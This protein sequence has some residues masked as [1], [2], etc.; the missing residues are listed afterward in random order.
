MGA[1]N[2]PVPFLIR[3]QSQQEAGSGEIVM[4]WCSAT[5]H[6]DVVAEIVLDKDSGISEGAAVEILEA[7]YLSLRGQDWDCQYDSEFCDHPIV[8][9]IFEQDEEDE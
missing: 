5:E 1:F 9:A 4:G 2:G 3:E 8:Q 7:L 6:F